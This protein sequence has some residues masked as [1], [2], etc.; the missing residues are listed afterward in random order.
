M[1]VVV[2]ISLALALAACGGKKDATQ[3]FD[4]YLEM[5]MAEPYDPNNGSIY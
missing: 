3:D 1:K 4:K 2:S 5:L